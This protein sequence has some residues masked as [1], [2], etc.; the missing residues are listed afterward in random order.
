MV[1]IQQ[2]DRRLPVK[3]SKAQRKTAAENAPEFA[4]RLNLEGKN[5]RMVQFTLA[6]LRALKAKAGAAARKATRGEVRNSLLHIIDLISQAIE[7]SCG[8]GAIPASQRVYQFKIKLKGI[9]PSIWRRI[10]VRDGT[11][12]KLH[13][14]IQLAMGWTNTH[15]HHFSIGGQMFGDP[16]LLE[17]TFEEMNYEDSTTTK[18]SRILPGSGKPLRFGYEYDFGDS[19]EHEVVFEGC[20]RAEPGQRYPLCLEGERACPP[21]DVGGTWGYQEFLQAI[22]DPDHER[23]EEFLKWSGPFNPEAFDP[24]KAT[25]KM[26]R[27]MPDWVSTRWL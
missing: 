23:H 12:D 6:E 1:H 26:R 27:G 20:L 5:Q 13:D 21:E 10:Q 22:A 16:M 24:V 11:L 7:N 25:N 2:P 14:R 18:L 17:E 3:L 4:E 15:Q 8:L 9:R 19:W